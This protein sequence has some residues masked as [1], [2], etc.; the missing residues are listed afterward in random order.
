MIN[1]KKWIPAINGWRGILAICILM[2][3]F[4]G[5]YWGGHINFATGYLAVDAFFIISGFFLFQSLDKKSP[6]DISIFNELYKKIVKIY[7]VYIFSIVALLVIYCLIPKMRIFSF[8]PQ[9]ALSEIFML[10]M[11]GILDTSAVNGTDWY[12]SALMIS[13]FL[14]VAVYKLN[15]KLLIQFLL[16]VCVIVFYAIC[17]AH[18]SNLDIH[19]HFKLLGFIWGGIARALGGLAI[20]G[21]CF[22][23][24]KKI[25]LYSY[26]NDKN[27]YKSWINTIEIISFIFVIGLL[28]GRSANILDY[29]FPFAFGASLVCA[30]FGIG[31]ISRLLSA[32]VIQKIGSLSMEIFLTQAITIYAFC[33]FVPQN[34]EKRLIVTI[35]FVIIEIIFSAFV[36]YFIQ[37][38]GYISFYNKLK[39]LRVYSNKDIFIW[40]FA[41]VLIYLL[42]GTNIWAETVAEYQKYAEGAS[43]EQS[44]AGYLT[45]FPILMGYAYHYL[46][47]WSPI[48]WYTFCTIISCI[49]TIL[50][51]VSILI[52]CKRKNISKVDTSC[53]LLALLA[54]IAHPSVSSLINITH[55]GYIPVVLYIVLSAFDGTLTDGMGK[56]PNIALLPL[57]LAVI[58]KP[59]FFCLAFLLVV[60]GTK[61]Y[62]RP[63]ILVSLLGSSILSAVQLLMFGG[64][65]IGFK[66]GNLK[67][68]VKFAISFVEAAG[69]SIYF[70]VRYYIDGAVSTGTIFISLVLGVFIV[71]SL[72]WFL[73][74]DKNDIKAWIRIIIIFSIIAA[75]VMPYLTIDYTQGWQ[76]V[77]QQVFSLSFW[78]HKL[79]YQ[80][81]SSMVMIAIF[82]Q[83]IRI[84]TVQKQSDEVVK[85]G[86]SIC[87]VL[88]LING[89]FCGLYSGHWQTVYAIEGEGISYTNDQNFKYAPNPDWD[90]SWSENMGGWT[91]GNQYY[92]YI[93]KPESSGGAF[94]DKN[95][96]MLPELNEENAK[97]YLMLSDP[98]MANKSPTDYWEFFYRPDREYSYTFGEYTIEFSEAT[99]NAVRYAVV[100]YTRELAEFLYSQIYTITKT[101][102][103][104]YTPLDATYL[105]FCIV[106]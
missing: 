10:Q 38:K 66:L 50:S 4:D 57:L 63:I 77:Q 105:N 101:N 103:Q 23:I 93:K 67:G 83:I 59:S 61:T 55:L 65:N 8:T 81:T 32:K 100:P 26:N 46:L 96:E 72:L 9:S 94:R 17:Y 48:S 68:I 31:I 56:L 104:N 88:A 52:I 24:I 47:S 25:E 43:I 99:N 79:Q 51:V 84:H 92:G 2:L 34:F 85:Q 62:K 15:K 87:V 40:I 11:S 36:Q 89:V 21:M 27:Q 3:H 64:D 74:K 20:G 91:K 37:K 41:I 98:T 80:L 60:V 53:I 42:Q 69:A 12:V 35:V 97:I 30:Y 95:S 45:L 106:W 14:Y 13:I 54:L 33:A 6:E 7:P 28:Y 29:I 58:S 39:T 49:Y 44:F 71:G 19:F 5:I 90:W 16:P 78:K 102:D 73:W 1:E 76:I 22:Y 18:N 75:C 70:P 82:V 86:I